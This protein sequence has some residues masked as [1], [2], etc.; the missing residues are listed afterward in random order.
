M[1]KNKVRRNIVAIVLVIV[2]LFF[3]VGTYARYSTVGTGTAVADVAKW[4]VSI[5]N[6]DTALTTTTQNIDFVISSNDYVVPNKL[7][8]ATRATADIDVYLEGTEVA[9]DLSAIIDKSQVADVIKTNGQINVY[10]TL[11]GTDYTSGNTVVVALP[12]GSAFNATNGTKRLRLTI[13]WT[14]DDTNNA[15]DTAVGTS[16]A[17][18][19]SISIPVTLT[20]QQHIS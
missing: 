15:A 17:E 14:N 10:A 18:E 19:R 3:I 13:E 12:G 5:K 20:A 7:A 16:T 1:H 2:A 6:G 8:P 11:E 4:N 9:V